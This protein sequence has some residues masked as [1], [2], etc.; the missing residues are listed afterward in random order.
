MTL[1]LASFLLLTVK[2]MFIQSCIASSESHN[3][4]MSSVPSVKRTLSWSGHWGQPYWCWQEPRM[5]CHRNMQF[6]QMLFL[7]LTKIW[8]RENGKFVDFN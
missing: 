3:I 7:K 5:V 1:A 6:M 2:A 4:R 8:Q